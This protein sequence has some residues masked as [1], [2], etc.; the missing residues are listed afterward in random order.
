MAVYLQSIIY[1]HAEFR[2]L[3][4]PSFQPFLLLDWQAFSNI[5]H[6][7]LTTHHQF[8]YPHE[9]SPIS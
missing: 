1:D 3:P 4:P 5:S 6:P 2:N 9:V 8:P 7:S